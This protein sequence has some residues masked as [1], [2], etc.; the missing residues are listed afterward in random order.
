M[1]DTPMIDPRP[2]EPDWVTDTRPEPSGKVEWS[3]M[4]VVW[5]RQIKKNERVTDYHE[6]TPKQLVEYLDTL[7]NSPCID[8][9]EITINA[10]QALLP[11]STPPQWYNLK[12]IN[13]HCIDWSIKYNV[14]DYDSDDQETGYDP[15]E[16]ISWVAYVI[17]KQGKCIIDLSDHD[18]TPQYMEIGSMF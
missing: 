4:R 2:M 1:H 7:A 5:N 12:H 3:T 14:G 13:N 18:P 16:L 15:D 10:A 6:G 9:A 8:N 11:A 17:E